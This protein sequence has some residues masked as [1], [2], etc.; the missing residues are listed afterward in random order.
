MSDEKFYE[1]NVRKLG[2]DFYEFQERLAI[3][4]ENDV[5]SADNYD[6]AKLIVLAQLKKEQLSKLANKK[7]L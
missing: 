7:L 4:L 2:V 6:E 1:L 5:E 3:F